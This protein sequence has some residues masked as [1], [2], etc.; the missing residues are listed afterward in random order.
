[1]D[2]P[3]L[4]L[5]LKITWAIFSGLFVPLLLVCGPLATGD[6]PFIETA[7]GFVLAA[8][9]PF[10][11]RLSVSARLCLVLAVVSTSLIY[12]DPHRWPKALPITLGLPLLAFF[13]LK[14]VARLLRRLNAAYQR[15][16][17]DRRANGA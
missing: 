15:W 2:I 12:G 13:I 16:A 14:G 1:L 17:V 9:I 10:S 4:L 7:V 3:L 5:R 8:A 11:K 6:T